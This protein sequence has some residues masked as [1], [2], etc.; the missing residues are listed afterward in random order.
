MHMSEGTSEVRRAQR[1]TL[2]ATGLG[3]FMIF[4]DAL[5]VNV[6]LPEIQADF[7]T[8][9]SGLQWV[10]TAY[11]LGMAVFMMTAATIAD[12]W[13]RRR[14]YL[15]AIVVFV[16]ASC[17][18]GL[19]PSLGVLI[20]AR[21]VQGLSAAAANVTSLALVSAS[22]TEP[23]Q[24]A[25]AI[26]IWT[27]IA[28]AGLAI[29]PTAGGFLTQWFGWRSVF[30]ANLPFAILAVVLTLRF[31]QDRLPEERRSPDLTGQALYVL[32]IGA[33]AFAIIQGPQDGWTSPTILGCAAVFGVGIVVFARWELGRDEPMMDVRLFSH[34]TYTVALVTIFTVLAASYGA[35]LLMTQLWQS[36]RGYS[37]AYTGVLL[38]SLSLGQLTLAPT[39]GGW[40]P[41]VGAR[42]LILL[43]VGLLTLGLLIA[44]VGVGVR[45]HVTVLG[46]FVVGLGVAFSMTPSTNLAMSAVPDDRAGM[47]SGI[48]SSQRALGSTVGYAVMGTILAAWI[49]ATLGPDL[50]TAVPDSRER[51]GVT[52]T[53]VDDATP[54]AYAEA[55][56]SGRPLPSASTATRDEIRHAATDS[57]EGGIAVALLVGAAVMFATFV[58]GWFT[59]P[60]KV[61]EPD[62]APA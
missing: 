47:A 20:A 57:F 29:G 9:E 32:A 14:V 2:L 43:G 55:I 23:S 30:F 22:F 44:A 13:G 34:R 17:A 7:G 42:R 5:I 39:I 21:G 12:R 53:I 58:L 46:V 61:P 38:L 48:L 33:F 16:L 11:S 27:S 45:H 37:A 4:L 49:G 41:K 28:S 35:V 51:T 40:I 18:C 26:G 8:G 50:A 15:A 54:A 25:R 3:L 6:A 10:V 19:A 62:P 24:R 1:G 59:Y 56:G 60:R 52:A 31:V 36:V